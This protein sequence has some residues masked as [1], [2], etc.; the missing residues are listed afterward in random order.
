MKFH[1]QLQLNKENKPKAPTGDFEYIFPRLGLKGCAAQLYDTLSETISEYIEDERPRPTDKFDIMYSMYADGTESFFKINGE[2]MEGESYFIGDFFEMLPEVMILIHGSNASIRGMTH[3]QADAIYTH[4]FND[5]EEPGEI[6]I[7][8]CFPEDPNKIPDY[9][10]HARTEIIGLLVHEMQHAVQ[11]LVY[12]VNLSA[13]VVEGLESHIEDI[14]EV[15]SRVEEV[16][17]RLPE[18]I[19]DNDENSFIVELKRYIEQ[20]LARNAQ[21]FNTDDIEDMK[22]KMIETHVFHYRRKLGKN[23]VL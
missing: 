20:Y 14:F 4:D 10:S 7:S 22:E 21:Q 5:M 15:D 23:N 19:D 2:E 11:K 16:L 17:G 12:G 3:E 18:H 6:D 13:D 8:I 1:T 9:L